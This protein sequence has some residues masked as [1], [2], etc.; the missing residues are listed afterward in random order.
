MT[1]GETSRRHRLLLRI[2]LCSF[3]ILAGMGVK[4]ALGALR[5]P[6]RP[7]DLGP[8]RLRVEVKRVQPEDVQVVIPGYGEARALDVVT[9]SPKIAGEILEVH[10]RLDVGEVIPEGELLFRIDARDYEA[11]RDQAQAQ[12][13][14]LKNM[15]TLLRQQYELDTNRLETVRRTRDIALEEFERD[16]RLYEEEDV[17]SGSMVNLS[18]INYRKAQDAFDQVDQA[19][20]LY[21]LRIREAEHGLEAAEAA[22]ELV[23]LS[24]ERTEVRAPFTARIKQVQIEVGQNV[25]PG[26]PAVVLADDS[27]LEISV[28]LDSRDAREWLPFR[29]GA[30]TAAESANWF[31]PLEPVPCQI[32]WTEDPGDHVW[33]GVLDRVERFD[34][35]TR[36]VTVAVRITADT[37]R[38]QGD[39]IPLV[40][41]MFCEVAIPGKTMRQVYRLPRWAVSFEGDAYVAE[42]ELLRRR[43]VTVLRN[44]GEETFV[45]EGLRPGDLVIVTRLVNPVPGMR[46]DFEVPETEATAGGTEAAS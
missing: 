15:I 46:L 39:G 3:F 16:K 7:A 37:R 43:E 25:A 10:P 1:T 32:K 24:V 11:S 17:G 29:D 9:I 34:P 40:E 13:D 35:M 23:Q 31:G 27:A 22:L 12:V 6:P 41:G 5:E 26:V 8:S 14:R 20:K 4:L 44:Q 45:S 2:L 36:T 38:A 28:P 18:E 33:T 30:S 42:G 19:I 21:P